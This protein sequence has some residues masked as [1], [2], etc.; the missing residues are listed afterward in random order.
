MKKGPQHM[1]IIFGWTDRKFSDGR[2]IF[3]WTDGRN[4]FGLPPEKEEKQFKQKNKTNKKKK[5]KK[6][7]EKA[8][9]PV[10]QMAG[11]SAGW[12]LGRS[13][14]RSVGWSGGW[15]GGRSVGRRLLSAKRNQTL[16]QPSVRILKLTGR[17]SI[18][19]ID[20][21]CVRSVR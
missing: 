5:K 17:P 9:R 3:R 13:L 10:G 19:T 1:E 21:A 7:K 4:F 2:E 20:T 8:S 6:R 12:P 14:G 15:S 18:D 16:K 11:R